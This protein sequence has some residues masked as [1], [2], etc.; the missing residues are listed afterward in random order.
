MSTT[1]THGVLVIN[2][3]RQMDARRTAPSS[4]GAQNRYPKNTLRQLRAVQTPAHIEKIFFMI[5]EQIGPI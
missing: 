1:C 2:T 5:K 3:F 4:I